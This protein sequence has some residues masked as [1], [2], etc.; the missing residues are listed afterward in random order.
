MY[1]CISIL[2]SCLPKRARFFVSTATSLR[3]LCFSRDR[4]FPQVFYYYLLDNLVSR[5]SFV[6]TAIAAPHLSNNPHGRCRFLH[7]FTEAVCGTPSETFLKGRTTV[8][9][10]MPIGITA[11]CIHLLTSGLARHQVSPENILHCSNHPGSVIVIADF[12]IQAPSIFYP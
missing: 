7:F 1:Y 11:T 5:P 3:L 12:G 6:P 4:S 9:S 10:L 8:Q 2:E